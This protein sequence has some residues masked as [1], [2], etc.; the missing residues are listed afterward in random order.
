MR[1]LLR[2]IGRFDRRIA[3]GGYRGLLWGTACWNC[4]TISVLST[5]VVRERHYHS[6][7]NLKVIC[8][9]FFLG[10][11][12]ALDSGEAIVSRFVSLRRG[13]LGIAGARGAGTV[14]FAKEGFAAVPMDLRGSRSVVRCCDPLLAGWLAGCTS[15]D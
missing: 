5:Y 8:S 10:S 7:Q 9:M 14:G 2:S 1:L 11:S 3:G 13:E 6:L 12:P 15:E 4:A